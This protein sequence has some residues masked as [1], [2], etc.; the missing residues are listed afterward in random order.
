MTAPGRPLQ[1]LLA[2]IQFGE[3]LRLQRDAEDRS[4]RT[5][6]GNLIQ[7][8]MTMAPA[9][10][11]E[12]RMAVANVMA[13]QIGVT[14]EALMGMVSN[15]PVSA[16]TTGDAAAALQ[17][18]TME[19][20]Y[21]RIRASVEQIPDPVVRDIA[22][23]AA[24]QQFAGMPAGTTRTQGTMADPE[25]IADRDISAGIMRQLGSLMTV[26]EQMQF[27]QNDERIRQSWTQLADQKVAT[28]VSQALQRG[29]LEWRMRMAALQERGADVK[30][31]QGENPSKLM[32][33][34]FEMAATISEKPQTKEARAMFAWPIQSQYQ[35]LITALGGRQN[36]DPGVLAEM[37][38]AF[39]PENI[40]NA[41]PTF[42][43]K[44]QA[45]TKK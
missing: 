7:Q 34:L 42:W 13:P 41:P 39:A 37:D 12:D 8:F 33:E 3:Q 18:G 19:S 4:R 21:P 20:L 25:K 14:P 28:A 32:T 16:A 23:N 36:V 1:N 22:L 44:F 31:M 24:T 5:A 6:T 26:P 2:T 45:R 43:T 9:T 17:L 27:A 11:A 10:K 35:R 29:E 15:R 40:I 38:K 30:G